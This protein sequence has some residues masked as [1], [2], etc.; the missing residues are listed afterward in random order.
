[1][2]KISFVIVSAVN[3][4]NGVQDFFHDS[5][6]EISYGDVNL[7]PILYQDDVARLS[8]DI[9]STQMGNNKMENMAETKL[10]NFNLEKSCFI[11]FGN[12]KSR[13][14]MNDRLIDRPLQLCGVEMV[15]EEQAKYLGDQL[16][17]LG[18]AQ[19]VAAT[20]TKRRGL[21][22]RSIFE[23]RT[24][25]DD[26]R[27]HVAGGLTAGL[28]IWEIAVIPMLTNN[29]DC[30]QEIST[31]TIEILDNLQLMF[32]RCLMAVGSGCPKP[33]LFSETGTIM[34]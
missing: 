11:V 33:A 30:W 28:D 25:I 13:Q 26:C 34:M 10:L 1:M 6:Y 16:S 4:D 14:E 7:Q 8:L 32:L 9:E 22:T 19:S 24:V 21:V 31:N 12:K 3:L 2:P 5:E 20:V 18:L 27:S 15:Q 29:A 17:G 23:I